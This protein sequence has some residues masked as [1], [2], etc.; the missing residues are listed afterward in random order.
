[1]AMPRRANLLQKRIGK[2]AA[3]TWEFVVVIVLLLIFA[4]V[5]TG[6]V[7]IVGRQIGFF[8]N[9]GNDQVCTELLKKNEIA[10]PLGLGAYCVNSQESD[11]VKC[12]EKLPH[13]CVIKD[14]AFKGKFTGI[15]KDSEVGCCVPTEEDCAQLQPQDA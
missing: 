7:G 10:M 11:A 8:G 9:K 13:C 15:K 14:E 12:G 5:G 6:A 2:R 4:V 1:M 3:L